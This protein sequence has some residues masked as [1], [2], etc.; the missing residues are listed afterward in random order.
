MA[1]SLYSSTS[2][3][4]EPTTDGDVRNRLQL[5]TEWRNVTDVRI[6]A[7][8]DV[9]MSTAHHF[10]DYVF[11]RAGNCRR[12][13]LDMTQVTFFDCAGLSALY[14]IDERCQLANVEW[15]VQPSH[16]VS[17]VAVLCDA[18]G[19]LPITTSDD[20]DSTCAEAS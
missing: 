8:G 5:L 20:F 7:V 13:I 17:R 3:P 16:W 19:E 18:L 12:L 6:T 4:S 9:D 1:C 10:T 2:G 11:R 15:S 14:Y